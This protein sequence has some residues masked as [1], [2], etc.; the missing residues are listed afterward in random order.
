MKKL[1]I[2]IM[3]LI[4][5]VST[6]AVAEKK[7]DFGRNHVMIGSVPATMNFVKAIAERVDK[8]QMKN[9]PDFVLNTNHRALKNFCLGEGPEYP[10]LVVTTREMHDDEY[11]RCQ[12]NIG[13]ILKLKLGYEAIVVVSAKE[14]IDLDLDQRKLFMAIA[15]DVPDPKSGK[16]GVLSANPYQT[17]KDID[18]KEPKTAIKVY[19]PAE[20]SR[21]ERSVS[22]LGM[23]GGCRTWEWVPDL[24]NIQRS[25]RM[26]RA[27][28]HEMREDGK[29]IK[30]ESADSDYI[31]KIVS[32]KSSIGLIDFNSWSKN[33]N[34][35]KAF[36][37]NE[38]PPTLDTISKGLYPLSR[39]YYVY[40]KSSG[41]TNVPGLSH[42]MNELVNE[43]TLAADGYLADIGLV[44]MP[45][46]EMKREV[47]QALEFTPMTTPESE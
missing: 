18:K 16:D 38:L 32:D 41:L 14:G 7:K 4:C 29:Y 31:K 40:I 30:A 5:T 12:D 39:Q 27:L 24:K 11:K 3:C 15:N 43:K 22:E 36:S 47:K 13:T 19:G 25:Y 28:C 44:A 6:S 21:D 8:K 42:Y 26:Y 33:K 45:D 34:K 1:Y 2:F 23:E 37:V 10:D 46:K 20:K 9:K 17:W 35:L